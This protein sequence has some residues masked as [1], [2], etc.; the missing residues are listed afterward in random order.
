MVVVSFSRVSALSLIEPSSLVV[1]SAHARA[2]TGSHHPLSPKLL[3]LPLEAHP[4]LLSVAHL[5]SL[6]LHC[7]VAHLVVSLRLIFI[8]QLLALSED[9]CKLR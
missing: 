2:H 9:R 3:A 1:S 8:V 5:L 7:L 6:S 4:R